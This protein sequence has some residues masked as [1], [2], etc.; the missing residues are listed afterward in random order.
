MRGMRGVIGIGQ[1]VTVRF[2]H[3]HQK[4]LDALYAI[5]KHE[6][7]TGSSLPPAV[8]GA[9]LAAATAR[10]FPTLAPMVVAQ[11]CGMQP[12]DE[13]T[14][15]NRKHIEGLVDSFIRSLVE[16]GD[17]D[18]LIPGSSVDRARFWLAAAQRLWNP[19]EQQRI[20]RAAPSQKA[21]LTSGA[22]AAAWLKLRAVERVEVSSVK[23]RVTEEAA[24][25][26]WAQTVEW[27]RS[28]V[29]PEALRYLTNND[30]PV[31][32]LTTINRVFLPDQSPPTNED[33][34]LC[35]GLASALLREADDEGVYVPGGAFVLA[36]PDDYP[37]RAWGVSA[38]RVWAQYDGL[39]LAVVTDDGQT[40]ASF[41]WR[42]GQP[43]ARWVVAEPAAPLLETTLAALWR[44]LCVAGEES[45]PERDRRKAR[46]RPGRPRPKRRAAR[47]TL[48][49]KR[50]ARLRVRDRRQW[51]TDEERE[52]IQR[53]AHGVRGHLRRLRVGWQAGGQARS[54]AGEFGIALPD[55]Y[56]F[57]RPHVRGGEG[58]AETPTETVVQSRGLATVMALLG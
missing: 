40:G 20:A 32:D 52:A 12:C 11:A 7:A 33:P 27:Q 38:L 28:G 43:I 8:A 49:G 53:R 31:S 25:D 26:A 54:M 19:A 37:L 22:I 14:R 47:R 18:V 41:G 6:A 44:D 39:W 30:M 35:H 4:P 10:R 57:V 1:N 50:A 34:S 15:W 36:L 46:R 17:L 51:G 42:P 58:D 5:E 9:A 21:R 56:T 45:V 55:G 24:P 2:L 16:S 13:P 29:T 3:R 23:L 48:P